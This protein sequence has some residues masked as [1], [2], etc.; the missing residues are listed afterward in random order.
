MPSKAIRAVSPWRFLYGGPSTRLREW[1]GPL[2]VEMFKC[3]KCW[4]V[5]KIYYS[6]MLKCWT[7]IIGKHYMFNI[8]TIQHFNISGVYAKMS[9]FQHFNICLTTKVQR[10]IFNM[11]C[12]NFRRSWNVEMLSL[13]LDTFKCWNVE[14]LK[15]W[16]VEMLKCWNVEMLKCWKCWD[17][18]LL[19]SWKVQP[20]Y[21]HRGP[22]P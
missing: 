8:S 13:H 17:V 10:W 12:W 21:I 22:L 11:Q 14:M 20:S 16:N 5:E 15:G 19:Q 2:N 1:F 7:I 9:T 18:E 4:N 3:W 6:Q